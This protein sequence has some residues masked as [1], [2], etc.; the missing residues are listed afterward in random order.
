LSI[1]RHVAFALAVLLAACGGQK[2]GG[3]GRAPTV[4]G[5]VVE[6]TRFVD[7]IDAVGTAFARE[8]TTLTSTVTER[9]ESLRF[10]DGAYVQAGTVIAVLRAVEQTADLASA[11]ARSREAQQQLDRLR[12]LQARGFATNASIDSQT[13]ARD[14]ARAQAGAIRAQIGD[15]IIRAPFSGVVGLRRLSPGSVVTA[16]T[17]I[18]TISDISSIKLDFTVPERFISAIKAGQN[19]EARAQAWPGEIFRGTIEGVEPQVDPITR[20]VA[21]RALLPNPDRRL[22]PGM[23]LTVS[24]V[25]NP[26]DA[27]AVPELALVAQG[28]RQFV[29]RLDEKNIA[30]R[31]PVEVGMRPGGMVGVIGGLKRGDRIV[32]D[33]V[34]KVRDDAEVRPVFP[35]DAEKSTTGSLSGAAAGAGKS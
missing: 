27:L 9:V 29:F 34:V 21:V 11:E 20:S 13:A 14:Q 19:I 24:I 30:N 12:E 17:E 26:R 5:G 6:P 32:A 16:G 3:E 31:V 33:G 4:V 1:S 25:T 7:S 22:R 23:L 8:S 28:D 15:R 18:A 2:G 35:G 10:T